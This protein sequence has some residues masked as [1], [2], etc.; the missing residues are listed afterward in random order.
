MILSVS[1]V[2]AYGYFTKVD[3]VNYKTRLELHNQILEGTAPSPYRYRILVPFVVEVFTKALS[4]VLPIR[5]SFLLSYGIYDLLAVFFLLAMLFIWLRTWFNEEALIGVLFVAATIPIALQDHNFQPWSLLE[6]GLFS[7]AL[8]AIDKKRFWLLVFIVTL[9]TLNRETAVFI[10][11]AY[12]V[13]IDRKSDLKTSSKKD[14][15]P[16]LLFSGLFLIWLAIFWGLR[17]MR[18]N[19]LQ[20]ET[21]RELLARNTIK[22]SLFYAVVNGS[23]FLGGLWVFAILGYKNAPLFIK[24]I[25]LIIPLYL[26]TIMVWGVWYEVRLLMPLYP[27]LVPLGL[28]YL[29]PKERKAIAT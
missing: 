22:G 24:R 26:L 15:E 23:L 27:I 6:A 16:I 29:F 21:F 28:Y 3:L 7:A 18:G 8:L 17:Y 20:I 4:T 14:W 9:A 19:A 10:P 5:A 11:L 25:A 13:T 12:L 1:V 2:I